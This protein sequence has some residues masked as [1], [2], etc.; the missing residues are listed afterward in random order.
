M[1]LI[2][3]R[4]RTTLA[5]WFVGYYNRNHAVCYCKAMELFRDNSFWPNGMENIA[6]SVMV[7]IRLV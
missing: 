7:Q 1:A 4:I 6:R 3:Q 5:L 2:G